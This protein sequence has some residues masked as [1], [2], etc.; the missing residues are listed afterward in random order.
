MNESRYGEEY[1]RWR[2]GRLPR[3]LQEK[4]KASKIKLL[5]RFRLENEWKASRY[6]IEEKKKYAGH[7][8]KK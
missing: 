1:R 2:S 3:Y 4:S 6:W 5:A 8:K 7:V